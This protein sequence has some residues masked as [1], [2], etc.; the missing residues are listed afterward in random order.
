MT[1]A[2]IR[3]YKNPRNEDD[4]NDLAF[5]NEGFK[6]LGWIPIYLDDNLLFEIT[7]IAKKYSY[8]CNRDKIICT[9]L[10]SNDKELDF[11][12]TCLELL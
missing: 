5:V 2:T 7:D 6:S 10:W 8:R 3:Y 12:G 1:G 4:K 11:E 9:S